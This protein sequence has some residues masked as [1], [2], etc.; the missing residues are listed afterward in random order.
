MITTVLVICPSITSR[1]IDVSLTSS[2]KTD[3]SDN[4]NENPFTINNT[5][6]MNV[7]V[8]TTVLITGNED[9]YYYTLNS[10]WK[11]ESTNHHDTSTQ[12][13][14]LYLKALHPKETTHLFKTIFVLDNSSIEI[15]VS[16]Q[17]IESRFFS[18]A[19]DA[20]RYY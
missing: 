7:Y 17:A 5:G 9:N 1:A 8:K 2:Y 10:Y 3:S 12:Y 11:L 13:T 20:F 15:S 6:V 14:F 18:S 19:E 4:I 16:V